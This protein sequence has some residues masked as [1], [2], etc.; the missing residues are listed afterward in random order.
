MAVKDFIGRTVGAVVALWLVIEEIPAIKRILG[1]ITGFDFIYERANDPS[2]IGKAVHMALNPP[3]GTALFVVLAAATL[4]FWSTKPRESRMSLPFLGMLIAVICFAAFGIWYLVENPT[5]EKKTAAVAV[6]SPAVSPTPQPTAVPTQPRITA[7]APK[8]EP[9]YLREMNLDF[10]D[11]SKGMVA[12]TAISTVANV[13][14]RI[15]IEDQEQKNILLYQDNEPF[16]GQEIKIGLIYKTADKILWWGDPSK[17]HQLLVDP[18]YSISSVAK[19]MVRVVV[20][21][22]MSADKQYFNSYVL[23]YTGWGNDGLGAPG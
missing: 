20:T 16:E 18:T 17:K 15:F 4:I 8:P 9:K 14:L 22:S 12:L 7:E 23:I 10:T 19:V 13:Q 21:T 3:P 2:W 11:P 1:V 6:P 5:E